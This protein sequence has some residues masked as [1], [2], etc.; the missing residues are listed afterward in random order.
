MSSNSEELE[1]ALVLEL[2]EYV[3]LS[4]IV[5]RDFHGQEPG[6]DPEFDEFC[7]RLEKAKATRKRERQNRKAGRR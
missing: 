4:N 6:E 2:T 5:H 3:S 7:K 1:L